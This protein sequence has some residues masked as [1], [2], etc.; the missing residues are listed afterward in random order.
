MQMFNE[1]LLTTVNPYT[2]LSLKDEPAVMTFMLTNENDLTHHFGNALLADKKV[3]F[4]NKLF[5]KAADDFIEQIQNDSIQ[6]PNTPSSDTSIMLHT[7]YTKI[8]RKA[9]RKTTDSLPEITS[10]S[11]QKTWLPGVSKIF[12]NDLEYKWNMKMINH[13]RGIGVKQPIDT[14]HIWGGAPLFTLP[15]LTAGDMIDV[16]SYSDGEFLTRNPRGSGNAVD[17]IARSQVI[18]M[19]MAITEWNTSAKSKT[20]DPFVFPVLL[21][22]TAAFQG[23]DAPMLYGYSQDNL[24]GHKLSEWSSHNIPNIIGLMPAISLMYRQQHISEAQQTFVAELNRDTLFMTGQGSPES[25]FSTLSLKHKVAV[26]LPKIKELPWIHPSPIP[27]NATVFTNLNEDF[28]PK[29]QNYIESDTGELRRDWEKGLFTINTPKT[30]AVVGWLKK[31]GEI[32]LQDTTFN[33]DNPKAVVLLTSLDDTPLSSS[34][35]I[36]VTTVGRIKKEKDK[37]RQISLVEPIS[38]RVYLNTKNKRMALISL[39]GDGSRKKE[40]ILPYNNN[41]S[42]AIDFHSHNDTLWYILQATDSEN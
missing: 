23:W 1:K 31:S 30:Q 34:K 5:K 28:I 20:K 21:G 39:N 42:I 24:K 3:P 38:G 8:S 4:H 16:H 25:A 10:A 32:K 35:K 13:M 36:L 15:A 7:L 26:Q 14:S 22:A 37:W 33:I 17:Y 11:I 40:F 29:D 41:N 2:G 18:G 9:N 27:E 12:L 19:P 6:Q